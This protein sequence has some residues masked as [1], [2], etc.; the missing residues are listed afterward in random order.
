[1]AHSWRLVVTLWHHFGS[2]KEWLE[3]AL[4]DP[5]CRAVPD[6]QDEQRN[7]K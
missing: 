2:E 3:E 7:P 6:R 1:M 4:G 5:A